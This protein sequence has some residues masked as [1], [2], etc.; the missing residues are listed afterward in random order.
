MLCP[1]SSPLRTFEIFVQIYAFLF[2]TETDI[3]VGKEPGPLIN[4]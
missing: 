2:S 4:L 3:R 1:G